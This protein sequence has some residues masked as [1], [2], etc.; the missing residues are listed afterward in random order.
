MEERLMNDERTR[1]EGEI[2]QIKGGVKQAVGKATGDR[3]TEA[4][5]TLDEVK[6][7]IKEGIADVGDKLEDAKKDLEDRF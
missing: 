4:E 7:N 2:D 3:R 6:G 1:V 5:G